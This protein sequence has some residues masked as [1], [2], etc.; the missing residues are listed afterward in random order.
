MKLQLKEKV[1][2]LTVGKVYE[3]I[4]PVSDSVVFNVC[5]M[6]DNDYPQYVPI[7]KF[8]KVVEND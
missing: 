4:L 7:K 3:K 6:N 8:T 5:V 2:G 1:T